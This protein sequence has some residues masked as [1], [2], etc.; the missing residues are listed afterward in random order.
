MSLATLFSIESFST[1]S[2]PN[3]TMMILG[4]QS[5]FSGRF[6]VL[7]LL[8]ACG[9]G[10]R[11]CRLLDSKVENCSKFSK[12]AAFSNLP[13]T[14]WLWLAIHRGYGGQLGGGYGGQLFGGY[15]GQLFSVIDS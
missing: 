8:V 3:K 1:T 14:A 6:G 12:S 13:I 2:G 10:G 11:G 15:G 9:C 4:D 7:G 5:N